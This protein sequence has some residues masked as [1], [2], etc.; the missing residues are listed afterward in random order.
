MRSVTY[1]IKINGSPKGHIIPSKGIHQG[2]L[3]SPYLF[4]LCAEGLS[5]LIKALVARGNMKGVPM[6][7]GAPILSH[8]FFVDDNLIFCKA[9]L[10]ECDALQKV[11]QVYEKASG[12]QLNRAKTSL[13]FS[14]NTLTT[15]KEEIKERF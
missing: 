8:L 15:I 2:D 9:S 3:L 4:L 6:R 13:F 11:L 14:S 5:A 12:Q 7:R 10:E 1:F